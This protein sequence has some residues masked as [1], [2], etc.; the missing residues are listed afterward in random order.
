MND[1]FHDFQ[2]NMV[3]K[4]FSESTIKSYSYELKKF[5]RYCEKEKKT[6]HSLS[7]K[8]FLYEK[9]ITDKLSAASLK[10]SIGAVKFFLSTL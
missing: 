5:L 4:N 10:Q 1:Y 7:F 3:I 6:F 9:R 2:T 8:D